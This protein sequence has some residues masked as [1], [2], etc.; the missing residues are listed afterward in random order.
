MNDREKSLLFSSSSFCG[1]RAFGR[2][3]VWLKTFERE[4][5]SDALQR[6]KSMSNTLSGSW[7]LN[8]GSFFEFYLL[9]EHGEESD[10]NR[11]IAVLA[12]K[13]LNLPSPLAGGTGFNK[14][15]CTGCF[16]RAFSLLE[17]VNRNRD[18]SQGCVWI[19]RR[20]ESEIHFPSF[21]NLNPSGL[22]F[23]EITEPF[24]AAVSSV[25]SKA[26]VAFYVLWNI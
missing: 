7:S 15:R 26:S 3:A 2:R 9:K 16:S 25:L 17:G 14:D 18:T 12:G 22:T 24:F 19:V 10:M 6:Y 21:S 11:R 1:I 20:D 5:S 4:E 23:R 13:T 8:C